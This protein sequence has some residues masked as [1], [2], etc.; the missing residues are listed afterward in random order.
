MSENNQSVNIEQ[1]HTDIKNTIRAMYPSTSVPTVDFYSRVN[2]KVIAP[3]IF[4]E[5]MNVTGVGTSTTDQ[6]DCVFKFSAYCIYPYNAP[7][8]ILSARVLAC[9]LASKIN[10]NR[11]GHTMGASQV[12]L[13]EPAEFDAE[14]QQ[15]ET[16]RVEWEQTGLLGASVFDPDGSVAPTEIYMGIAPDT[17]IEN[18]S[19]Y[20]KVYP[21]E[22]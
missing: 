2:S 7:N 22:E 4:F 14:N 11:F 10:G 17:G 8:A 18:I 20:F 6:L 3:A 1:L 9:S 5:L 15:Y 12:T 16:M 19:K 13:I 21:I